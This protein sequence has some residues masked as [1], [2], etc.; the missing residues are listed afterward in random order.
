MI[1]FTEC[2]QCTQHQAELTVN[3][4]DRALLLWLSSPVT[5]NCTC[6]MLDEK[7]ENKALLRKHEKEKGGSKLRK[8][9]ELDLVERNG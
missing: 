1:S 6:Q 2:S 8:G 7:R 3:Q 9:K 5:Q 4:T